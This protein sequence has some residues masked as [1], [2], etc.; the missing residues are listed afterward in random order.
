MGRK[1]SMSIFYTI[2]SMSIVLLV[3]ILLFGMMKSEVEQRCTFED[4]SGCCISIMDKCESY[5]D[6]DCVIGTCESE[7]C[8]N[9]CGNETYCT[10]YPDTESDGP[11]ACISKNCAGDITECTAVECT[12]SAFRYDPE[13]R[14]GQDGRDWWLALETDDDN[15]CCQVTKESDGSLTKVCK[16]G[17][18]QLG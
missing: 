5:E 9:R 12:M 3:G 14:S 4:Q 10:L 16:D 6:G 7:D 15:T 11:H 1:A 2:I 17:L 13:T 8:M 18:S